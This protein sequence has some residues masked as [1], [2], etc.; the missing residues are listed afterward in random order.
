MEMKK[1]TIVGCFFVLLMLLFVSMPVLAS[2]NMNSA[3]ICGTDIG[4]KSA[5]SM[6]NALASNKL[7]LWK[8]NQYVPYFYDCEQEGRT[9]TKS[10]IDKVLDS[11]F[12]DSKNGDINYL[13]VTGHGYQG[14]QD[15]NKVVYKKT[16]LIMDISDPNG[17]W[18]LFTD[19]ARK[20]VSYKGQ[21]VIFMD[22]C[23]AENFYTV[24]L[25]QFPDSLGRFTVFCGAKVDEPGNGML[26]YTFY[27]WRMRD[28][29]SFS[30]LK[31]A[32]KADSNQDGFVSV[33]EL[34]TYI[35][36]APTFVYDR[37]F[38]G[39]T[40][41]NEN[42]LL[43]QFGSLKMKKKAVTLNTWS[44][45][46]CILSVDKKQCT[47]DQVVKWK[48]SNTAVASVD[49]QGNVTAH[50]AGSAQITAY[51]S[52]NKGN[53]CLGSED[54]CTVTVEQPSLK[55]SASAITLDE[56]ATRQ[57]IATVKGPNKQ[58]KWY[59]NKPAVA[60]VDGNGLVTGQKAG[61]ATIT[62]VANGISASC[63]VIVQT[64]KTKALAAYEKLLKQSTVG[65]RR[66]PS[67]RCKFA[68]IYVDNNDVPELLVFCTYS[69]TSNGY[70]DLFTY[71]NGKVVRMEVSMGTSFQYYKKAGV[72]GSGRWITDPQGGPGESMQYCKMQNGKLSGIIVWSK[73]YPNRRYRRNKTEYYYG[74]SKTGRS[75]DMKTV[76]KSTYQKLE[77][78][79]IGGKKPIKNSSIKFYSNTETNR[80]RYLK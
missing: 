31:G 12:G 15:P 33:G 19:L 32:C 28:G 7:S 74:Y 47:I 65:I 43:F 38:Y 59:T 77:K 60:K 49:N 13:Y 17:G 73:Y 3:V 56:K 71:K 55:L 53:M 23:W 8:L 6:G 78:Q 64:E 39:N 20:L 62:A 25:S 18:Y 34:H 16:G 36:T 14:S 2:G 10:K 48:S 21:F 5:L 79:W 46:T 41:G 68:L 24:G 72:F 1:K 75:S 4:K 50:K 63:T 80:R 22:C 37:L 54:V 44:N 69:G 58:V 29:L 66:W 35:M 30:P 27:G 40:Y 9:T 51:L 76:S 70:Y 67:K 57:I 52:D 61:T 26:G 45:K 42:T 11:A